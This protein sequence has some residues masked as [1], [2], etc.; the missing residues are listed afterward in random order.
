MSDDAYKRVRVTD[1][2][3]SFEAAVGI[4]SDLNDLQQ[5]VLKVFQAHGSL[6]QHAAIEKFVEMFGKRADSTIRT[7]VKELV[8]AGLLKD[9]GWTATV[10]GGKRAI[11]WTLTEEG[12]RT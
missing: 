11:V 6:T 5:K 12:K 1:P 8:D 9:S 7:R 4:A 2:L 3:T 10:A